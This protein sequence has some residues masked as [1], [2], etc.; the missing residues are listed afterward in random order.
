[1]EVSSMPNEIILIASLVFC[2]SAVVLLYR[3]FGRTG[4]YMWT[5]IATISANIEALILVDAFG[6]EQTLGNI[7][8]A[9]TFLVTDILSETEGRK[10]ANTAVKIG[11]IVSILFIV[12]SQS[13]FLYT[14]NPNDWAMPYIR[15]VFSNTPRLML[16]SIAVYGIVQIFD[17]CAYHLIWKHTQN[18]FGDSR[19]GL[20]IRNNGSTLCSQLLNTFLFTFGAF[21]GVHALPVLLHICVSSYIIFI[22]TSLLDTPAVYLAR[23]LSE[24]GKVQEI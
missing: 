21:W 19:K 5:V 7:L 15:S 9:S 4:L 17:V 20:W 18:R 1:M 16:V 10:Y 23:R 14:P 12:I 6:M 3:F 8:F 2:Y 24:Q 22:F 13:W 11:I